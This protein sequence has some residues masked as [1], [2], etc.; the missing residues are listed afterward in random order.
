LVY[1]HAPESFEELIGSDGLPRRRAQRCP[2]EYQR[3]E[4]AWG[5]LLEPHLRVDSEEPKPEPVEPK[6]EPEDKAPATAETKEEAPAPAPAPATAPKVPTCEVAIDHVMTKLLP[7]FLDTLS[8]EERREF[9]SDPGALKSIRA[10]GLQEC[11]T[12]PWTDEQRQCVVA[13]SDTQWAGRCL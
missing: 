10:D 2:S 9:E 8:S 7:L 4:G 12:A 5:K 1:G 6:P 3:I 13:S 11:R